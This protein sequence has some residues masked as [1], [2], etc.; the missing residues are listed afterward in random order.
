MFEIPHVIFFQ[1]VKVSDKIMCVYSV[2]LFK[3]RD[4]LGFPEVVTVCIFVNS[5]FR[6]LGHVELGFV[7]KE[8][9]EKEEEAENCHCF[10]IRTLPTFLK[11]S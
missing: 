3:F 2:S 5:L 4:G 11:V 7:S 1:A 9:L 8:D 10:F 6:V